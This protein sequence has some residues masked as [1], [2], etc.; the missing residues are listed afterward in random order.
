M[1]LTLAGDNAI[2]SL[3]FENVRR[4]A[5]T[6]PIIQTQSPTLFIFMGFSFSLP[7]LEA[8]NLIAQD[9]AVKMLF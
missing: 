1:V 4:Y 5:L 3:I 2:Y 8:V 6:D 9:K 7:T